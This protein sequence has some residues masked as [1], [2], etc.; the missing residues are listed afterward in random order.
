MSG[1]LRKTSR[2]KNSPAKTVS[3]NQINRRL[4]QSLPVESSEW[5]KVEQQMMKLLEFAPKELLF[6]TATAIAF[7]ADAQARRGYLLGREDLLLEEL[8][9]VKPDLTSVSRK[10][11]LLA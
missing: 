2:R 7:L 1:A 11:K 3:L 8:T 4:D 5:V 10:T 9:E 6:E